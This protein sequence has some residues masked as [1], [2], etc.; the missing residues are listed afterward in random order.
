MV[1]VCDDDDCWMKEE[2][3][4]RFEGKGRSR[5]SLKSAMLGWDLFCRALKKSVTLT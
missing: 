4:E 1:V 5:K 3:G 2:K